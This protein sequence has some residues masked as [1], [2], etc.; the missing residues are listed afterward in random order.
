VL[1]LNRAQP[2]LSLGH[3]VARG[4]GLRTLTRQRLVARALQRGQHPR[5]RQALQPLDILLLIGILG[6]QGG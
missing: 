2:R 6:S 3:P 4:I 1:T 5:Q